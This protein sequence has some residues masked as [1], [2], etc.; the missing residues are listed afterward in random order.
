MHVSRTTITMQGEFFANRQEKVERK[1]FQIRLSLPF[2]FRSE[3]E[4]R[5]CTHIHSRLTTEGENIFPSLFGGEFFSFLSQKHT[6]LLRFATN[7]KLC[8]YHAAHNFFT[9]FLLCSFTFF[10]RKT[11][12]RQKIDQKLANFSIHPLFTINN[13]P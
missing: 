3:A 2:F 10:F 1:K 13:F 9:L 5:D 6:F 12:P 4:K 7:R 11:G 8:L